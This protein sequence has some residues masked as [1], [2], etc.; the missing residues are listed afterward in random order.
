[1]RTTVFIE[2]RSVPGEIRSV[3]RRSLWATDRA[4]GIGPGELTVRVVALETMQQL[5]R[6]WRGED[7]PT[8]VLSFPA[9]EVPHISACQRRYLGDVAICGAVALWQARRRKRARAREFGELAI[10]GLLHLLGYDHERDEGEMRA[11]ER[12]LCRMVASGERVT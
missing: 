11:V 6:Q 3:I 4:L 8:D 12:R 10:H 9:G 7:R 5:N 1:M 2:D